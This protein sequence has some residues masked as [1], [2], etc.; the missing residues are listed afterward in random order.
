ML[1][2]VVEPPPPE[3][4]DLLST[5][6]LATLSFTFTV[7]V[8]VVLIPNSSV[9]LNANVKLLAVAGAVKD[10]VNVPEFFIVTVS[11]AVCVHS[12]LISAPSGSCALPVS[13]TLAITI[14]GIDPK[15]LCL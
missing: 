15:Y 6:T 2:K 14:V 12:T 5:G 3:L 8:S 13:S 7:T 11:P 10:I 9:A 1:N 4:F